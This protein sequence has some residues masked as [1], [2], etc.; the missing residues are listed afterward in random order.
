MERLGDRES[1]LCRNK[2]V[3][4][5]K[6]SSWKKAGGKRRP[7]AGGDQ[8]CTQGTG[9]GA[10]HFVVGAEVVKETVGSLLVSVTGCFL[11]EGIFHRNH[12]KQT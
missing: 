12:G 9:E 3:E 11:A 5:R 4:E 7:P 1:G 8:L 2:Q 10:H 6:P